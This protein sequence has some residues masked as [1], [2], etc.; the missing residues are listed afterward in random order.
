[1]EK[2]FPTTDRE[3]GNK[4][5]LTP[6]SASE[7]PKLTRNTTLGVEVGLL[8][9]NLPHQGEVSS[10]T[11]QTRYQREAEVPSRF[12]TRPTRLR[13]PARWDV[14]SWEVPFREELEPQTRS[15]PPKR[16]S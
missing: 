9:Q 15:K 13:I 14:P 1:M 3:G 8:L 4:L 7:L 12:E 6:R 10:Q 5:I 16:Q 2:C 11:R